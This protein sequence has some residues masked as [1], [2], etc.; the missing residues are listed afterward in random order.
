LFFEGFSLS[1]CV[2]GIL[3]KMKKHRSVLNEKHH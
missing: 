2:A 1:I 3:A